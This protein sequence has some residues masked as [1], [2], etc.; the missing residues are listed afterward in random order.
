MANYPTIVSQAILAKRAA[1]DEQRTVR[2][3]LRGVNNL[4]PYSLA[5]V[6]NHR[7]LF[8]HNRSTN[9]HTLDIPESVW[10]ANKAW[11]ARDIQYKPNPGIS[12]VVLVL[13]I[14]AAESPAKPL[15]K[16]Q[17]TRIRKTPQEAALAVLNA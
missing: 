11:M 6:S 13:P 15:P 7:Y 9:S 3:E 12:M 10:M 2:V 17:A 4:R 16:A 1:Q 8:P 14:K 5:G